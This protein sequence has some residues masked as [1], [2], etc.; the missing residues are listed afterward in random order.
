MESNG[1]FARVCFD[2]LS[3]MEMGIFFFFF[4]F[5]SF[6]I[7]CFWV[8]GDQVIIPTSM[9]KELIRSNIPIPLILKI[10]KFSHLETN[11]VFI[12][13]FVNCDE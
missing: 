8:L 9:Y 4:L 2:D 10:K 1:C 7:K 11:V 5:F 6:F 3:S 12:L 13:F